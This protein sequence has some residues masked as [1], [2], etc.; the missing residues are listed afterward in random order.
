M[1]PL[2]L[3]LT[4][5]NL[6]ALAAAA[7]MGYWSMSHESFRQWHMLAGALAALICC[8]VHCVVFTYFIATAKWMEHA[9]LVKN[10]NPSLTAPARSLKSQAL[11]AALVAMAMVFLAALLGV[12]TDTGLTTIVLHHVCV[13]AAIVVNVGAG[14]LELIAIRR[15]GLL[16]DRILAIINRSAST[17]V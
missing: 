2:F 11:P 12:M 5:A 10:L 16:I 8:A 6:A 14:V 13:L 9:V 7:G 4:L 17:D 15:N 3:G 1:I